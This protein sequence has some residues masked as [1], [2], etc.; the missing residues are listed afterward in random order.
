VFSFTIDCIHTLV[1]AGEVRASRLSPAPLG[2]RAD[3]LSDPRIVSSCRPCMRPDFQVVTSCV[4]G[5]VTCTSYGRLVRRLTQ[6]SAL[7]D[8]H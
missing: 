6:G 8:P 3:Y 1:G 4:T 5:C 7:T 2:A